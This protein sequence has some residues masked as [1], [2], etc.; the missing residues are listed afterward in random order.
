MRSAWL[1][2]ESGVE[3]ASTARAG[4]GTSRTR[5]RGTARRG[6]PTPTR[7]AERATPVTTK[8]MTAT[9]I[10]ASIARLHAGGSTIAHASG[11]VK[12]RETPTFAPRLNAKSRALAERRREKVEGTEN[13]HGGGKPKVGT[14][15]TSVELELR[16][17]LEQC[18]FQP[19]ISRKSRELAARAESGG[20][21]ERS[22]TWSMRKERVLEAERELKME[23]S[24]RDCTFQPHVV[25]ASSAPPPTTKS[26]PPPTTK[27]ASTTS[28]TPSRAPATTLATPARASRPPTTPAS[29][30]SKTPGL[31][32]H[33][34]RQA[35]ARRMREE[36]NAA[37][38][39]FSNGDAWRSRTVP[40]AFTFATDARARRARDVASTPTTPVTDRGS[41]KSPT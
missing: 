2:R 35:A 7:R 9:E 36:K 33:V 29:A 18:T 25:V 1:E 10:A 21:F 27:S 32:T 20:F 6:T 28:G 31:D 8:V 3:D 34:A 4:E 37:F 14:P 13:E 23:E 17:E 5:A 39:R 24:L 22:R 38:D 15:P 11:R 40:E 16:A 26:A 12:E 30:T 41:K 19:S